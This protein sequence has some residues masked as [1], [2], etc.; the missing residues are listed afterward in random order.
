MITGVKFSRVDNHHLA[1]K[2]FIEDSSHFLFLFS[3]S[4][5]QD[6][7][8]NKHNDYP[9]TYRK[10]LIAHHR[11]GLNTFLIDGIVDIVEFLLHGDE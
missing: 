4:M 1:I 3:T 8:S 10:N 5:N 6:Q 9:V 2:F 11:R 7:K